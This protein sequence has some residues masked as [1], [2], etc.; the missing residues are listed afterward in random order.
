MPR[1]SV[2]N[3]DPKTPYNPRRPG[4]FYPTP[5]SLAIAA[6]KWG[7]GRAG[8]WLGSY[9][10]I[11][12]EDGVWGEAMREVEPKGEVTGIEIDPERKAHAAYQE[13]ITGD[14]RLHDFGGK[15]FSMVVGNPPYSLAEEAVRYALS[16]SSRCLMLLPLSFLEG[17]KRAKGLWLEFP[18]ERVAVLPRRPSFF[19]NGKTAG[20]AYA[21]FLWKLVHLTIPQSF[22]GEWLQWEDTL[23]MDDQGKFVKR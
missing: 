18:P 16:V 7:L 20:D 2:R 13:W 11:G 21:L 4:D 15:Q 1:L 17:Q 10:D 19:R 23:D 12:A 14:F 3:P 8:G 9:L 6:I 5:P 22:Q